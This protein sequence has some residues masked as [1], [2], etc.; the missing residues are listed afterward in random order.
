MPSSSGVSV[1]SPG[2][3]VVLRLAAVD[4]MPSGIRIGREVDGD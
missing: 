3:V 4:G 1:L 2:D